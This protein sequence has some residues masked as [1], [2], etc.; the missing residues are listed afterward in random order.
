MKMVAVLMIDQLNNERRIKGEMPLA[1]AAICFEKRNI[2]TARDHFEDG[3]YLCFVNNYNLLNRYSLVAYPTAYHNDNLNQ[4]SLENK[5]LLVDYSQSGYKSRGGS[6]VGNHFCFA[7]LDWGH[8]ARS[9]TNYLRANHGTLGLPPNVR[10]TKRV[11]DGL[12]IGQRRHYDRHVA[13]S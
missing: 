5:L 9:G 2:K 4:R 12:Q 6:S 8:T 10:A 13:A 3:D 11:L 1:E 7:L